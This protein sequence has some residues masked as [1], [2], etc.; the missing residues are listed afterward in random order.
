MPDMSDPTK[1][2]ATHEDLRNVP[3]NRAGEIIDGE[4]IVTSEPL[5]KSHLRASTIIDVTSF[6]IHDGQWQL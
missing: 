6:R 5:W 4:L 2:K 1:R 3:E